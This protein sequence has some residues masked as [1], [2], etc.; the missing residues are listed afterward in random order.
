MKT[1]ITFGLLLV[2][3]SGC[4]LFGEAENDVVEDAGGSLDVGVADAGETSD[5]T[6]P[7]MDAALSDV[8]T[9]S[10]DADRDAEVERLPWQCPATPI[11]SGGDSRGRLVAGALD[12]GRFALSW[13]TSF[14]AARLVAYRWGET[15]FELDRPLTGLI[16]SH[17]SVDILTDETST[18]YTIASTATGV[19]IMRCLETGCEGPETVA[20]V[21]SIADGFWIGGEYP[22]HVAYY[23]NGVV[24]VVAR[25]ANWPTTMSSQ[26]P[27]PERIQ[28]GYLNVPPEPNLTVGTQLVTT[29]P[30]GV[31]SVA[32]RSASSQSF[33]QTSTKCTNEFLG[34]VGKV[35]IDPSRP[36][37]IFADL[38][39]D[40]DARIVELT[41]D[42]D[43]RDLTGQVA[44]LLDWAVAPDSRRVFYVN[45]R[46]IQTSA[47]PGDTTLVA[48]GFFEQIAVVEFSNGRIGLFTLDGDGEI[49]G[50]FYSSTGTCL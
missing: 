31:I 39:F 13:G 12:A 17:Q 43:P 2:L 20:P 26:M 15:E 6:S 49:E 8:G 3:T 37:T 18:F 19:S 40:A 38:L 22:P 36:S 21:Q 33:S 42:Q 16:E 35:D 5:A 14:N 4:S 47:E 9:D 32:E 23:D 27:E 24:K 7:M 25:V 10:G 29:A 50:R 48:E 45:E 41:C 28:L 44:G 1:F 30:D 46:G 11:A 34:T